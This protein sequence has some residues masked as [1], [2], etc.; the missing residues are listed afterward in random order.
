MR[1]SSLK[2]LTPANQRG[3]ALL[4]A[5]GVITV[6]LTTALEFYRQVRVGLAIAGVSRDRHLTREMAASGAHAAMAILLKD[7]S[8]TETDTLF[9]E[10]A[11]PEVLQNAATELGFEQG[12][13]EIF[14][15]DELG[16]IQVNAL[17]KPPNGNDFNPGQLHVWER[18]L[19][20]LIS[21]LKSLEVDPPLEFP[22][23][24]TA[25]TIV[26]TVKDWLDFGDDDN[27]SGLTGA[28]KE[29]YLEQEQPYTPANGAMVDLRELLLIKGIT[30][31]LYYGHQDLGGMLHA[32]T[33]HGVDIQ[34]SN[35]TY[36]GKININTASLA[37]LRALLPE[38]FSDLAEVIDAFRKPEENGENANNLASADWLKNV[39]G[40][41]DVRIDPK[42][43]TYKS[44]VFR[45]QAVASMDEMRATV[46][47]IVQRY[48]ESETGQFRCRILRWMYQ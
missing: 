1:R 39:P 35:L 38:G 8:E 45:I 41:G 27:V 28:E 18:Y 43:I 46:T 23:E 7:R 14:I 19:D 11:D 13:L 9:E 4:L 25:N 5:L 15:E 33:V 10:W 30:E 29:Y 21:D 36:T 31:E 32:M 34:Q 48:Q 12:K 47:A 17:V 42:L 3:I 40:A 26:N 16:R 44:D 20:R 2:L 6:L 22:E 24:T 37:V